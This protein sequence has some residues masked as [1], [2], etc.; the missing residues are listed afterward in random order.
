MSGSAS[1]GWL[2]AHNMASAGG[3]YTWPK[4]IIASDGVMVR[5]NDR[6]F[7]EDRYADVRFIGYRRPHFIPLDDFTGA[8]HRFVDLVVRRL[9]DLSPSD[10]LIGA[11]EDFL[12]ELS[13]PETAAYRRLEAKLG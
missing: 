9:S 13:E 5:I 12:V 2:L 1:I 3:G 11:W 7:E 4:L 8:V 10:P 6:S